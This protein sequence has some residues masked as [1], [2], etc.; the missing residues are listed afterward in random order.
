MNFIEKT[1][2][3]WR[4]ELTSV[5]KS[6]AKTKIYKMYIARRCCIVITIY[7]CDDAT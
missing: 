3:T 6:V 1:M 2:K 5:E 7:N 4:V